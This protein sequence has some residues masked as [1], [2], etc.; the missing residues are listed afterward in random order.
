MKRQPTYK[1]IL[2]VENI[3]AVSLVCSFL[4]RLYRQF[5]LGA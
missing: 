2:T 1:L 5:R 4:T 3:T